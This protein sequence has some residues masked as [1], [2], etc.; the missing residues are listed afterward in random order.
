MKQAKELELSH[1]EAFIEKADNKN[2]YWLARKTCAIL[3]YFGGNRMH[4][5]RGLTMDD[6]KPVETGYMVTF[7]HAK[8]RRQQFTSR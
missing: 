1:L 7:T 5:I 3:A 6:V 4:E 2:R 8:Q